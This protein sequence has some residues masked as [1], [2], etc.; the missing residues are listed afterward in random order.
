MS[1]LEGR[2]V[3]QG[4][5]RWTFLINGDAFWQRTRSKNLIALCTFIYSVYVR[6]GYENQSTFI[7]CECTL[8]FMYLWAV[9]KA[10]TYLKIINQA[11]LYTPF[12]KDF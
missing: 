9:G 5:V 2:L 6:E 12:F 3:F 11:I 8:F 1:N 7:I 4:I 10:F